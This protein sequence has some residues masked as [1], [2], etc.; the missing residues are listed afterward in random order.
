MLFDSCLICS[1]MYY[2][3]S[4]PNVNQIGNSTVEV[5]FQN[6]G[7]D[8]NRS[9]RHHGLVDRVYRD[10]NRITSPHRKPLS[11]DKHGRQIDSCPYG[12]VYLSPPPDTSWRRTN[13]DSALHQ[14]TFTPAQQAS[15][16]GGSQELQPKRGA[17]YRVAILK[18]DC[19]KSRYV[20][21]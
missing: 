12:A 10:R 21:T 9:T 3:G 16:T 18:F 5:P 2:G 8:T 13:S 1:V 11:F 19:I 17:R 7:M 6:S 4:L 20:R 15:F 14:S